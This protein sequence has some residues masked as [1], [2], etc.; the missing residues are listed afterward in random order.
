M[1]LLSRL[2][3][4][5]V[6]GERT[7]DPHTPPRA[8]EADETAAAQARAAAHP[9]SAAHLERL[10][11]LYRDSGRIDEAIEVYGRV[12]ALRPD[13]PS[14]GSA[15]LF[16]ELYRRH[17]RAALR[18]QHVAW[19]QRFAPQT[20][21]PA[22]D[23]TPEPDRPLRV[24]YVSADLRRSSAAPFIE[25]LLR[26]RDRARFAAYCYHTSSRRDGTTKRL[27]DYA[28]AWRDVD[29]LNDQDFAARVLADRVDIL[30]EL[31]GHTRGNRLTSLARRLAPVQASYLGYG[32]TTGVSAIDY[33][34]TDARIDPPPDAERYYVER[35]AYLPGAM[36]CF[37]PPADAP[38]P[39]MLP[40]AASGRVTFASFNYF[41]KLSPGALRAWASILRRLPESRL[42]LIGAP[43]GSARERVRELFAHEGVDGERLSFHARADYAGYLALMRQADIALDSF[44]YTGGATTCD[45]LWMGVPVLTLAGAGPMER[46]G[47]SLL[48]ALGMEDWVARSED[49]YVER[50]VRLA[51]DAPA[52]GAL[53]A[54]LRARVAAS[55]LCDAPRFVQGFEALLARMWR[56]WCEGRS[57]LTGAG[58]AAGVSS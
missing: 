11:A 17:D 23:N 44:P 26:H 49:D 53:R 39:G 57:M 50:A 4:D 35:L 18:D 20:E 54:G 19:A 51:G 22:L 34:I 41:A 27:R 7:T 15:L 13:L 8:Q 43:R 24:G 2:L 42:L 55:E 30:L 1:S 38:D 31:N 37:T 40:A 28:D 10:A 36:W 5:L 32:A 25:P 14:A 3:S 33:R 16:H 6:R 52:L 48:T 12:A 45:A 21:A 58:F 9:D 47:L 46:S 29:G 56:G